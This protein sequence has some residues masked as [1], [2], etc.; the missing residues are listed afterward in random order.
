M[1]ARQLAIEMSPDRAFEIEFE[2]GHPI[3][4]LD[5]SRTLSRLGIGQLYAVPGLVEVDLLLVESNLIR[6]RQGYRLRHSSEFKCPDILGRQPVNS[7]RACDVLNCLL[8]EVGES[9]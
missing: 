7:D 3:A 6:C 2:M 8:P 5:K 9:Q 1:I 4:R